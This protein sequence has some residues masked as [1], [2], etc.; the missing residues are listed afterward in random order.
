MLHV[1]APKRRGAEVDRSESPNLGGVS[2][3]LFWSSVEAALRISCDTPCGL[4]RVGL[5]FSLFQRWISSVPAV[6]NRAPKT[7]MRS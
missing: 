6:R 5:I 1:Q 7:V 3:S 2:W 4:R